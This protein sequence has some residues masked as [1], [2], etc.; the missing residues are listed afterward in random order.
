MNQERPDWERKC[1]SRSRTLRS[2]VAGGRAAK[3]FGDPKSPSYFGI[4]YSRMKWLRQVFQVSSE[5]S[6]WSWC[7]SSL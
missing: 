2:T 4:S 6:L 7:R 1:S 5:T 3:K